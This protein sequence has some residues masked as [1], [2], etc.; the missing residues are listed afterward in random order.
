[1]DLGRAE[2]LM[3]VMASIVDYPLFDDSP[4]VVLSSTLSISSLQLAAAVRSLCGTELLLGASVTLRSQFEALVR[5]VWVLH[6][7]TDSD[8]GKL[9]AELSQE[10][11]QASKN[12]PMLNAMLIELEKSPHLKNLLIA[13]Q[14]FKSSSWLPLNSFV[15]SGIHAVHWTKQ[16]AHPQ[17][18][19]NLFRTSNGLALIAFQS[20]GMLTGRESLQS[21]INIAA[22]GFSDILPAR[23][24]P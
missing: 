4:R 9:S 1:M 2:E 18:L 6:R 8:V 22:A 12:I 16:G 21:E 3:G 14:E 7:A 23:R 13:L 15:H 5:S 11:Q 10:S 17:L 24:E 20:I 19:E